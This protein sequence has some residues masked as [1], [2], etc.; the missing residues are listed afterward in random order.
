M[1][2]IIYVIIGECLRIDKICTF[3]LISN[4][5]LQKRMPR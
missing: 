5:I 1:S 3:N 4:A 2:N